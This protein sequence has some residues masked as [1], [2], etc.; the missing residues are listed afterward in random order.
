MQLYLDEFD[1][2]FSHQYETQTD[3]AQTSTIYYHRELICNSIDGLRVDLLTVSSRK[4]ILED[5]EPRLAGLFP[6]LATRRANQFKGK[7]V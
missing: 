6:D 7:K 4:G 3:A 2:K 1:K 5:L